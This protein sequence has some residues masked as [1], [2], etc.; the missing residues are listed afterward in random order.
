MA[1]GI[2]NQYRKNH[3]TNTD[4]VA[5]QK[6]EKHKIVNRRKE[7]KKQTQK[8]RQEM[9]EEYIEKYGQDPSP[10]LA[11]HAYMSEVQSEIDT[12]DE[13]KKRAHRDLL[14]AAIGGANNPA[15]RTTKIWTVRRPGYRAPWVSDKLFVTGTR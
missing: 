10:F 15:V 8:E 6:D 14:E 12:D 2:F 13:G 5:Q 7:R 9:V 11:D 3:R 4:P 1:K